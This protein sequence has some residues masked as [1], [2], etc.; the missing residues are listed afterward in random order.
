MKIKAI[1]RRTEDHVRERS[2][3]VFRTQKNVD[4]S[5]HPFERAREYTRA[6][7]ATKL[8]R[9]FAAPFVRALSG[10]VD[11]V[12][13]LAKHPTKLSKIASG[14]ADGEVRLWNLASG[15]TVWQ[16]RNAHSGFVRGVTI[17]P[18]SEGSFVTVGDD[19][20][21]RIWD[22]SSTAPTAVYTHKAALN[23]VDH[24]RSR[25]TFAT[26]SSV[27]DIW[28]H[29]RAEPTRTFEWGTETVNAVKFNQTEI[30]I[31]ASAGSDRT[32]TLYDV[33]SSSPI[34]KVV[35]AMKTNAI[36]WNPME[37]FNFAAANEDH[38]CYMFDMRKLDRARN[39]M[40]DH[41]SAVLDLD[42]SPTGKE[43]VTGSYDRSIRIFRDSDG[44]SREVYHTKRMQRI[45]CVKWSMDSKFVMS[46]S[47][48][49]NIRLW[50]AQASEKLGVKSVREQNALDY[51]KQIKER[52]KH[53]PEIRR[54]DK[55]R[56]VPKPII[57]AQEE[58]REILSA[59]KRKR[60]NV[61]KHS[62][63]VQKRP[64]ERD[65]AILEVED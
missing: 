7:N 56:H 29:S 2:N 39:V 43:I 58:K 53:I 44:H 5:L 45:F 8:E 36:C 35:L 22:E 10:H 59:Q 26:A 27:V 23:A 18:F 63:T 21:V 40:K 60:D 61:R 12:Y 3:D 1:S 14:S 19:Q 6:L 42:Y 37:A 50:K 15:A 28:D 32:I 11:G 38:N 41:V 51:A 25:T 65:R 30:N 52:Y 31:L 24:H 57:K 47:D 55:Q 13:C 17:V 62:D 46:G 49:G 9:L 4:P 54:I 34:Q 16:N 20:T 33:R 64:K 48:D